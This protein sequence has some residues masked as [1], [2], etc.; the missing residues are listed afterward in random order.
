LGGLRNFVK[1]K[2]AEG[3]VSEP[4]LP[5]GDQGRKGGLGLGNRSL[6]TDHQR[7]KADFEIF[8]GVS[9]IF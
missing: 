7:T 1:I 4:F 5:S 8:V 3:V 9:L 2:L 6:G